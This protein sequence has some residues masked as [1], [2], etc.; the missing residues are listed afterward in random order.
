M[1][2]QLSAF[3]AFALSID[4]DVVIVAENTNALL[5]P[6]VAFGRA[7]AKPIENGCDAAVRQQTRKIMD[8]QLS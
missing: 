1:Q 2:D 8:Q 6:G 5:R 7:R 3:G 4:N